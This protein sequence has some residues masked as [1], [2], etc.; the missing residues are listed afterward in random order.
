MA[1][2]N[3]LEF[4][5]EKENLADTLKL[6]NETSI[7]YSL[8]INRHKSGIMKCKSKEVL[9]VINIDIPFVESYNY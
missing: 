4:I 8:K 3:D 2:A 9:D 5:I 7:E 1:Y 6:S